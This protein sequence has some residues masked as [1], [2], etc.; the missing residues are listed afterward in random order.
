MSKINIAITDDSSIMRC[1]I[2]VKLIEIAGAN[3]VLIPRIL[4]NNLSQEEHLFGVEKILQNC[5]AIILPGNKRDVH[6]SLYKSDF[7]HPQTKRR[8]PQRKENIRQNVE[9][10][11]LEFALAKQLPILGICGG[12]Q[13]TNAALGGS[14]TQHLPEDARTDNSQRPNYHYEENLKKISKKTLDEFERDFELILQ[15][16]LANP[17]TGTH[18]M[19]IIE[20]SLLA[21]IYQKLD[22]NINLENI[23]ELSIH[24]QGIFAEN[25]APDLIASAIAPDGVIEAL[26]HKNYPSFFLLTQFHPECNASNIALSLIEGLMA[27]C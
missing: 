27:S 23:A 1:R 4:E 14:L 3:P 25:M 15:K 13:L 18:E 11:M 12:M 8:L 20:N 21:K 16:K 19:R 6:P 22:P 24:H 26:E 9:L 7:I 5:Q 2:L 17:F 10:K